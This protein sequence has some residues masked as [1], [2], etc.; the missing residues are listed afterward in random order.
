MYVSDY[1]NNLVTKISGFTVLVDIPVDSG[2]ARLAYDP[3]N[4]AM[5]AAMYL[6]NTVQVLH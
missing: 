1:Y 3:I 2:P 5:Y 6:S 4:N